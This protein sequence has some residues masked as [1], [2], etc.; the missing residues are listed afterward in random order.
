MAVDEDSV[1]SAARVLIEVI[2]KTSSTV[3]EKASESDIAGL[4]CY[5]AW[6]MNNKL[7]TMEDIEQYKL[8]SVNVKEEPLDC[9]QQHLD[10]MYFLASVVSW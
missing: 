8:N 10:V 3:L 6:D 1:D 7:S 2:S 5:T 4:Q 9:H